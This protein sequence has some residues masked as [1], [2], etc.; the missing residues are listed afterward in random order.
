MIESIAIFCGS[1]SGINDTYAASAKSMG[2]T[3]AKKGWKL[4]YGGGKTGLMGIVA[5]AAIEAGGQ[6]IGVMP[7]LLIEKEIAH[8]GLTELHSVSNMHERKAMMM[9][10]ADA[11]VAMPGGIGTLEEIAE[12]YTWMQLGIHNKPC[13]FLNTC[14][15]YGPLIHFLQHA[16][17]QQ[18][19]KPAHLDAL[20]IEEDIDALTNELINYRPNYTAKWMEKKPNQP[21]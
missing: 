2:A 9:D 10:L 1:N 6:V 14:N 17:E 3:I 13:A 20:I 21:E 8:T 15:F 5:D 4:I 7:D 16:T 19:M 12:A 18:F 11:F